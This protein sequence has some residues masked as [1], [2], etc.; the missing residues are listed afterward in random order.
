MAGGEGTRLRPLTSNQPKPMLPMANVPMMEHVVNLLRQHG[1][2]DIVVTVAFMANAIRT[3]F[4]DGSEFGVRMVYATEATPLGTAGSVRNARD[5]LD[6]RFL[7]ISGDVLTDIDLS[8]VVAFHEKRGALATLALKAV[9]NPL[10]F[11]IVIT[12]EDGTVERFLEKPTWGQVFSDTINTGI[13]V[14]E[15]EIFDYI[16]DGRPVDFS[17]ESFPAVLDDGSP[18]FGYVADGY[19]EDVGTLEAYLKAH[20]DILDRRVNVDIA[21]FQ[22]RPGVWLGKGAQID[23]IGGHRGTGGHRRQL[24]GRARGQSRASTAPWDAT[25][26]S[27]TTPCCSASWSTTTPTS[28]PGSGSTA[29]CWAGAP[30]CARGPAARRAWSSGEHSLIGAGAEIKAGVKVYPFKTVEAGAI[31]NSSIVWE[32]RGAR[33]LFGRD[34]VRGLANVDIS[35]ELAVRL[36]MAWASTLEKGA[37]V[38]TSRDTSRAARVLKRAIMVGCNAA[39]V[40]VDDLEAATVP[41]TRF[42]VQSSASSAGIT[43]RLAPDD[44]ESVVLRFFD[45]DGIDVDEATQRKIE[46]LY[47]REDFRRVLAREIGDIGF[48]PRALEY[49]TAGLI[50]SVDLEAGHDRAAE[51]GP[52]LLLRHRQLR[53]AQPPGQAGGR[54]A[55]GQP[56]R[57]HRRGHHLRPPGQRRPAWRDL[58]RA[59]GANLGAVIDPGGEHVTIVDDEGHR[60]DRR[61]GAAGAA[62]PGHRGAP[63]GPGGPCRW[64]SPGGRGDLRGRPTPRSSGPSSRPPT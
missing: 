49:Y 25:S 63:R 22:L 12:R 57:Q 45:K 58:V 55:G 35:P 14:L 20:Q 28:A 19:W 40:N 13:Y 36:S 34:G 26:A 48:P 29:A 31:V 61:R 7:V 23:P 62:H 54:G 32:S 56:L 50:D 9:D 24:R 2:E 18:L 59:S 3:Y 27:A 5:E 11:G 41:V 16:P 64:R 42:Q 52:R 1:F 46:R 15:P 30:T 6:E 43:V 38:T 33:S 47:Y 10:E 21:G 39:G 60:P 17:G 44:P 37:T 51:A 4:G 8:E 53:D